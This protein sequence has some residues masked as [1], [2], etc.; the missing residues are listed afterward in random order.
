MPYSRSA[1]SVIGCLQGDAPKRGQESAL[2]LARWL[3][4]VLGPEPDITIRGSIF[5]LRRCLVVAAR[6]G[7]GP[8]TGPLRTRSS[9]IANRYFV[10][11]TAYARASLAM[12]FA[13]LNPSY[14]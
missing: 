8:L 5:P 6:S 14:R 7:E 3:A 4:A 12:G 2:D 1:L 13:Q 10:E 9:R 11:F